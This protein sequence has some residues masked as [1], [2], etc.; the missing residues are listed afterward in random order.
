MQLPKYVVAIVL[1]SFALLIVLTGAAMYLNLVNQQAQ[2]ITTSIAA[3]KPSSPREVDNIITNDNGE[4][5][6][7]YSDGS[8]QNAGIVRGSAGKDGQVP[9]K[10]QLSAALFEYCAGGV[11]DAKQPTQEQILSALA[12][13]CSG[14]NCKG[15]RGADSTPVTA[16]QIRAAV[17]NYCSE[18]ACKGSVGA[19]GATGPAGTNADS[20]VIECVIR[21][22]TAAS[23]RYVAWKY[24]LEPQTSFRDIYQLPIWATCTQPVDLRT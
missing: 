17:A 24:S 23:T 13:Y 19:T 6:I 7:T 9:S 22:T 15:E 3:P 20:T 14:G 8:V 21:G 4:L 12:I 18:G 11:C 1:L 10:A 16:E 2:P 5:I